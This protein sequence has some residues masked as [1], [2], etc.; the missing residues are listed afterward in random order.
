MKKQLVI[1][2]ASGHG[3][4]VA[5][6]AMA[7]G[8]HVRGFLDDY[9]ASGSNYGIPILGGIDIVPQFC[10]CEVII[11][12]GNN[13]IRKKIVEQYPDLNY[14]RL[15][16]PT[17]VV[18]PSAQIG[19]GTVVMPMAVINADAQIGNHCIINS[20]VVVE[21]DNRL[22]DYVHISPRAALCGTVE[23]GESSW[24]CSGATVINN[25]SICQNCTI[26][27]GAVVLKNINDE[28][29]YVG[30]PARIMER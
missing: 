3:K 19:K 28:G 1:I 15:I 30:V 25:V 16:H 26:G 29:Y 18:S 8:Y 21:H 5:D 2:G 17:A 7:S 22:G 11:A 27:A 12:I 4:V 20:S 13:A 24:I 9:K 23:V 14:V 10:D 6:I